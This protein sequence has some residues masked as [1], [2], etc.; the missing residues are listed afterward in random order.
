M[1]DL[2]SA[3]MVSVW[4]GF[5]C[6]VFF[7]VFVRER[8]RKSD[9]SRHMAHMPL[10]PLLL[11][12]CF[13]TKKRLFEIN[14]VLSS[15]LNLAS[16]SSRLRMDAI[17]SICEWTHKARNKGGPCGEQEGGEWRVSHVT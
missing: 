13:L 6:F 7:F 4:W 8:V 15:F 9:A 5:V 16:V 14:R 1:V 11:A 3:S 17:I 10:S 12:L 2:L